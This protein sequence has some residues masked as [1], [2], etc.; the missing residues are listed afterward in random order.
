MTILVTGGAGVLGSVVVR[1]LEDAGRPVRSASRRS[2]PSVDLL[3]G[4]GLTDAMAGVDVV[5]HCATTLGSGDVRATENLISAANGAHLVYISIVGI[6]R[7]P[8]PYYETKLAVERLIQDSGL[9]WTILRTTQF[10]QLLARIWS[11]QRLPVV[12]A[13]ALRFQPVDTETVAARLIELASAPPAGR[14]DDLGGPKIETALDLARAYLRS[15]GSRR[16]TVPLWLPGRT[17]AAYRRGDHLTPEHADGKVDFD[18]FLRQ[19]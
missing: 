14:V 18:A 11:V 19:S 5:I 16:P 15:K 17:F 6:D 13:P 12:F 3:T 1:R 8:L 2:T 10:H 4:D 9:P 7:V